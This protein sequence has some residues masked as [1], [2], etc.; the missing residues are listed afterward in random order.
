LN[1]EVSAN[2]KHLIVPLSTI[3]LEIYTFE[4]ILLLK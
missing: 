1:L 3:L 2:A 4:I